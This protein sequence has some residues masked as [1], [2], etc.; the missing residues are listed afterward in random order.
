MLSQQNVFFPHLNY[1]FFFYGI[2]FIIHIFDIHKIALFS[3]NFTTIKYTYFFQ[4]IYY[5]PILFLFR[6]WQ[7]IFNNQKFK[8]KNAF[9]L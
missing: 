1:V 5:V 9:H 3:K 7:V 4:L 8:K 6:L 2:I